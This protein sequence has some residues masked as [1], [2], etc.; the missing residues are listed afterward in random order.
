M[1]MAAE[2]LPAPPTEPADAPGPA[3]GRPPADV[4]RLR[5]A[6]AGRQVRLP[7]FSPRNGR[8]LAVGSIAVAYA[9]LASASAPFS[10]RALISVLVP[11]AILGAVAFGRPPERITPPESV[12]I[13]GFSY[14][15][16]A[17]ALLFEW[18]ASA[19]R[20]NANWLHPTLT[21]VINPLLT[22]HPVRAGAFVIWLAAGW[23][24]VKR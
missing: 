11:G 19:F 10:T 16:V 20:E 4:I 3:G 13:T 14:W 22:P 2:N 15:I 17:L 12:D 5:P 18:E 9:W 24:L 21:D 1:L 23:A 7:A 6:R 8:R